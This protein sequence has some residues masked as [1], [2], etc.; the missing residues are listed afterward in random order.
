MANLDEL[1]A[2]AKQRAEISAESW[3]PENEGDNA[4]GII[5][6]IKYIEFAFSNRHRDD[7]KT[8]STLI[9]A[10]DG[11]RFRYNWMGTVPELTWE[12]TNPQIGDVVWIHNHGDRPNKDPNMKPYNLT[13]VVVIDPATGEERDGSI[14]ET[15]LSGGVDLETGEIKQEEYEP[16]PDE[17]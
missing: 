12:T 15:A 11:T 8:A 6:H 13:T 2:R 16:F 7:G 9:L 14:T 4:G 17:D 3:I 10:Q 1:L 5:E